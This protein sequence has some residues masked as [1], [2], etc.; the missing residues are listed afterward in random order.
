[1]SEVREYRQS[2]FSR[3][4]GACELLLVRH[5]ESVPARD[6]Q[7]V[8]LVDGHGDPEL[9][10]AGREQALRVAERLRHEDITAIYVTTLQRTVQTAARC[11]P[12]GIDPGSSATC[13]RSTSR[14][15][16]RQL[17]PARGRG[18]PGAARMVAEQRWDV[19]REPNRPTVLDAVRDAITGIAAAHPDQTVVVVSHGGVIGECWPWRP[20]ARG[21]TFTGSDNAGISHLVVSGDRWIIRRYND[22]AHLGLAFSSAPQPADLTPSGPARHGRPRPP[23]PDLLASGSIEVGGDEG[24]LV[25]L[26][27]ADR[28]GRL[29]DRLPLT[30][31]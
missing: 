18:S 15:G 7:P 19:I 10:P 14:V 27:L 28:F 12:L 11:R 6:D 17:P 5:G 20:G 8:A 13:A 16:G 23:A 25:V 26:V 2:R 3:P 31:R 29:D 24:V 9:A 1:M 30:W 4:P 22:T 21:F